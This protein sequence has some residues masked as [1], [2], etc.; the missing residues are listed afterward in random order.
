MI[1]L[2]GPEN[3]KSTPQGTLSLWTVLFSLFLRLVDS[4]FSYVNIVSQITPSALEGLGVPLWRWQCIFLFQSIVYWFQNAKCLGMIYFFHFQG[5]RGHCLIVRYGQWVIQPS[6]RLGV[7]RWALGLSG[8]PLS[9]IVL[10]LCGP[11]FFLVLSK[12]SVAS[13]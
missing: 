1:L 10:I 8:V 7:D 2:M 6:F 13:W 5:L 12:S 11:V 3:S 9:S 4:F